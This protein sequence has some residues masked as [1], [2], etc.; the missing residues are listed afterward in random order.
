MKPYF[1][2]FRMRL[3]SGLQYRSTVWFQILTRFLWG[4]FEVLAFT[5]VYS[6]S[7]D[8]S[9]TLRQTV[10]YMYM[11]QV[12][13]AMCSV[14][15]ADGDIYSALSKGDVAASLC[16]P[17]SLYGNWFSLACGS[18]LSAALISAPALMIA[19]LMPEPFR[20]TL[21]GIGTLFLFIVSILLALGVTAACAMLMY[22]SLFWLI[23]QR[24]IKVIVTAVTHFLAGGIIPLAFF[25]ENIR[26]LL[27]LSPFAAMQNTPLMIFSGALAGADI[28]PALLLQVFWLVVL[29]RLGELL[30][31]KALRRVVIQGG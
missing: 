15:F 19:L 9:M 22:I 20:A 13:Y 25:P 1:S 30:M 12:T 14:V 23:S 21:P 2:L 26:R 17:M 6:F 16:R 7:N 5:A 10:S 27:E 28:L 11:Q 29:I 24:G 31:H 3:L 8:F 4:F 18:R